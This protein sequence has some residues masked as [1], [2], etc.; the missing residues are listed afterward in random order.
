MLPHPRLNMRKLNEYADLEF[1]TIQSRPWSSGT[2]FFSD[3]FRN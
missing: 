1:S 3:F 2:N